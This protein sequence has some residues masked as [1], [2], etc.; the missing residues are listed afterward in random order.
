[1]ILTMDILAVATCAGKT[2]ERVV[3]NYH[4]ANQGGKVSTATG[5]I[6]RLL[7]LSQGYGLNRAY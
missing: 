1:M 7:A 5:S 4:Y 3:S 2:V 6:A